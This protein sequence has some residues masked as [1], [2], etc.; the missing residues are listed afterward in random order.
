M[1]FGCTSTCFRIVYLFG[2]AKL[3][4]AK[5]KLTTPPTMAK[6]FEISTYLPS[7]F[8]F[9]VPLS[10]IVID[11]KPFSLNIGSTT[12]STPFDVSVIL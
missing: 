9:N 7:N 5:T 1:L 2:I 12:C 6:L 11:I 4:I 10:F 8:T 3:I